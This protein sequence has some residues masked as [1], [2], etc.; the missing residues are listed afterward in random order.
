MPDVDPMEPSDSVE[1]C[2]APVIG[3]VNPL[4]FK[5]DLAPGLGQAPGGGM[6]MHHVVE[7]HL[8]NRARV[9]PTLHELIFQKVE[10][11]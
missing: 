9:E 4:G 8:P 3:E 1:S 10:L 7:V 11:T 5:D 6:A 2:P